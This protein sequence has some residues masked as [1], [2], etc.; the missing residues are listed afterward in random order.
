MQGINKK[1]QPLILEDV[2]KSIYYQEW[3]NEIPLCSWMGLPLVARDL[4]LGYLTLDNYTPQAFS[5]Q[6]AALAESFSPH[7]A[8]AIYNARLHKELQQ[9]FQQLETLN[10]VTAALSRSLAL[11]EVLKLILEQI[12]TAI[13]FD[14]ASIFLIEEETLKVAIAEGLAPELVGQSYLLENELMKTLFQTK[15]P[16][17]LSD[18][19]KDERFES[20]GNTQTIRGWMGIPLIARDEVI[21]FLTLDSYQ[22][23]SYTP[24]HAM[25]A[26]PLAAQAA[27]AIY[28]ARLYTRVIQDSNAL[29]K[30][31]QERTRELQI[32]VSLT[33]DREI[34]MAELK[35]VIAKLRTQLIEADQEPI[36]DDPLRYPE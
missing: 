2:K 15:E 8:Q 19:Q 20:W 22:A 4:V 32:F 21:G 6:D 36:A 14:S 1:H 28:N 3:D 7:I 9:N 5:P 31:V 12:K 11:D 27:Q 17:V 23:E 29:E 13:P 24:E 25:I 35:G 10:T 34:R 26:Q 30:R 33:A 18:A 16:L